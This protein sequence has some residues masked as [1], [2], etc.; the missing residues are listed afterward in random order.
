MPSKPLSIEQINERMN[1][2]AKH[3]RKGLS[4]NKAADLASKE[5]GVS[6]R[7]IK[8]NHVEARRRAA[9]GEPVYVPNLNET[10]LDH[11]LQNLL[12]KRPCSI[13][14]LAEK[15]DATPEE[16]HS[17]IAMMREHG[18][19]I[20]VQGNKFEITGTPPTSSSSGAVIEIVSDENNVFRFGAC[21]DSH[22]CSKYERLDV[23]HDLYDRYA[24]A[25]VRHVFHTGNWIDG[26]AR[27]NTHDLNVHGLTP[28][29]RYL[30]QHYPEREG[31]CTYAVTGD[32]HEG[33]YAARLGVDIGRLAYNA[34]NEAGRED[35]FDLG[36]MEAHVRL[37]NA[38]SGM[39]AVM[40]VIHPGGGSAYALSYAPQKIVEALDGGEKPA[41]MLIGHYHKMEA[42]NV[43]NVWALQTGCTQ[44]Q[45]PFMRKKK[46]AA[47]VGGCLVEL[48]QD[49]A[50]G[51]IRGFTPHMWRYFNRGYY[52]NRWSPFGEVTKPA[53]S[54]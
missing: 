50:T 36:Y 52:P 20:S 15:A 31:I 46:L 3:L 45:T 39:T 42:L 12:R 48:E 37:V 28:Q 30:A 32:D 24:A 35:W 44:D 21:G 5:L 53:R 4:L 22:L 8:D 41:V 49:P 17:A 51:A 38:N 18:I 43:R 7:R 1:V 2:L 54:P 11:R 40:S 23:L 19:N 25:G 16:V 14:E 6:V 9:L 33:W 29:L 26:E 47:H 34:M 13:V 10:P 27:F